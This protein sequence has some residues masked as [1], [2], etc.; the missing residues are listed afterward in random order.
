MRQSYSSARPE[1]AAAAGEPAVGLS[2]VTRVYR[3][4]GA[5]VTALAGASE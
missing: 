5:P 4:G 2:R 1:T 3:T